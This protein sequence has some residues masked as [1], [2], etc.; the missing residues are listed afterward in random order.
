MIE[1]VRLPDAGAYEAAIPGLGEL[2]L[3]AIQG[4]SGVNFLADATLEEA[5]AWWTLR[6]PQVE[7]GTITAFVA[8]DGQ[9]DAGRIVG[10]TLLIRSRN[11]NAPHRAEIGKVIV[12]RSVR[13]QG[14]ARRLMAA[15]EALARDEGRWLLLLDTVAGS[16]ADAMY[17]ALGWEAF[18][19]VPNHSLLTDGTPAPTTYFYKDLR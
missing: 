11:A 6:I 1:V 15:A 18:G 2:L 4:G 19:V 8:V 13:R 14:V 7:D 5:A 3:G 12:H 16:P 9:G 10:S 17:R